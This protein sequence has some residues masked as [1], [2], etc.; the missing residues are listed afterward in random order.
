MEA[1]LSGAVDKFHGI[2]IPKCNGP[3]D[4]K[5]VSDTLD[6]LEKKMDGKQSWLLKL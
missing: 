3:E 6:D 2:I 4:V 1:I 5:L